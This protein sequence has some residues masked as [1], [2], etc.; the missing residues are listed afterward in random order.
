MFRRPPGAT[1]TDTLFPYT[2]LFRS[3]LFRPFDRLLAGPARVVDAGVDDEAGGAPQ[4]HAEAAEIGIGIVVEAHVLAELLGLEAPALGIGC[5]AAELA[6]GRHLTAQPGLDRALQVMASNA[7]SIVH[8]IPLRLR[9][10]CRK[11]VRE[12]T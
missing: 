10:V 4:L 7:T 3:V 1:R 2:T 9:H 5:D 11:H 6:E 12:G 8:G